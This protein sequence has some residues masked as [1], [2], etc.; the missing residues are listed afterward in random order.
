MLM[1][2]ALVWIMKL[3]WPRLRYQHICLLEY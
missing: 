3:S 1:N 2:D